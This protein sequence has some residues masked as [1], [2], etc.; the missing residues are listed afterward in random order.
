MP[1]A[2]RFARAATRLRPHLV[3]ARRKEG[4]S[5]LAGL[6]RSGRRALSALVARSRQRLDARTQLLN[7]LGYHNVLARGFTLSATPKGACFAA[8]PR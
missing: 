8:P 3:A 5:G 7:S 2:S 6:D 4:A 1:I